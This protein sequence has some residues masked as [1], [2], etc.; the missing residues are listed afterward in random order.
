VEGYPVESTVLL[1]AL[2]RDV[3][4]HG[5]LFGRSSQRLTAY[6]GSRSTCEPARRCDSGIP[7]PYSMRLVR[8]AYAETA[9]DA[10]ALS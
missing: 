6:H 1:R 2:Q 7:G 9:V 10:P 5:G 8:F 4:G 3:V